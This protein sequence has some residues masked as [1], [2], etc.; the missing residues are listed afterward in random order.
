M[1]WF[2]PSS[3]ESLYQVTSFHGFS[4]LVPG[5]K[6]PLSSKIYKTINSVLA[7]LIKLNTEPRY[8]LKDE[9]FLGLNIKIKIR[10]TH[11]QN[12]GTIQVTFQ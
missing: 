3:Q 7:L 2:S 6:F 4:T 9:H 1:V 11:T 8:L 5:P 12:K 10:I